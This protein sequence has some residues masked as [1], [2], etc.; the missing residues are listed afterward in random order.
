MQWNYRVI[1]RM[2]VNEHYFRI[3]EVY[4]VNGSPNLV[5]AGPSI[6]VGD[7]PEELRAELDLMIGAF[8]LPVLNF[9]DF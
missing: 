2:G 4:Y 9:E 8:D 6:P 7:T 5:T 3:H 1:K